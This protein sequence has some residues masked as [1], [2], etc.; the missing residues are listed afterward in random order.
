MQPDQSP[1]LYDRL[2]GVYNIAVVVDDLIDRVMADDRLNKNPAVDEAHHRVTPPGFKYFVTEMVCWA[3]GG[4][5]QYSGRSMGDSHRHLRITEDEWA[6][7][8]D[9]LHQSL[10][11]FHVPAAEGREL[12]TIVESTKDAI[13][14]ASPRS[15]PPPA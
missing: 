2:G 6:A 14:A 15:G 1:S 7:F 5:Q 13:V 3:A 11:K 10:T 12:V 8:M 9:D 4:P